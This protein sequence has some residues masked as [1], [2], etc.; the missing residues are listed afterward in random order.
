M[1][2]IKRKK[3]AK[4]VGNSQIRR[5]MNFGYMLIS[6]RNNI[7]LKEIQKSFV[8]LRPVC[9]SLLLLPKKKEK[10]KALTLSLFESVLNST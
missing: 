6:L 1:K 7:R 9:P 4:K 2:S 8:S 5:Q 3:F 10:K